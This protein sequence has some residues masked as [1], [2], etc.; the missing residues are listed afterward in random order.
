VK[1]KNPKK[2]FHVISAAFSLIIILLFSTIALQGCVPADTDMG[3][4][5]T[6][7]DDAVDKDTSIT[8]GDDN[9]TEANYN[10]TPQDFSIQLTYSTGSLPPPYNYSYSISCGPGLKGSFTYQEGK[11]SSQ[12]KAPVIIDF[13]VT[14][15][16]MD[17]LYIFLE[18]NNFFRSKW[19]K[20]EPVVGGSYTVIKISANGKTYEI[21]PDS[22]LKPEDA[23]MIGNAAQYINSMVPEQARAEIQK[24]QNE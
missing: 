4:K 12:D 11:S 16:N 8:T 20:A 19:D 1:I 22:E 13:D 23:K 3:K 5:D 6:A 7:S 18:E 24:L 17:G 14:M 15:E 9:N 21:P 2:L 10:N